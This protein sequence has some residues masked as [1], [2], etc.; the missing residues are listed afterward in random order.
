MEVYELIAQVNAEI[1]NNR[2]TA[3]IDGERIV[4]AEVVGDGMALTEAGEAI[5]ATLKPAPKKTTKSTK[6]AAPA[7]SD[8]E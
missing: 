7:D 8:S 5:A 4:V 6:T 3:M 2:A 1:V